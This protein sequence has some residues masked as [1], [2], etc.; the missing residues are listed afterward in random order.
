MPL[1]VTR[2]ARACGLSRSTVLY[3]ES[4]GVL[5]PARRGSGNYRLYGEPDLARL[6]EICVYREAGLT[7]ADIRA[8]LDRPRGDAAAVLQRRFV[9]LSAEIEIL[10]GRQ[11][12]IVRLLEGTQRIRRMKMVTKEKWVEVMRNAGFTEEQMRRW[13]TEF[14]KAAP[15][16]HQEFLEFLHIPAEEVQRIRAWSRA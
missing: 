12:E 1:T 15:A 16:E 6:R 3:Y 11:R 5:K 7:L 9:E 13:H 8:I 2:L 4:V 14:E 10:R